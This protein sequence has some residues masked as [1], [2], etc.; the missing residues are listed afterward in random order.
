MRPSGP[1][2]KL[3]LS[4]A[5]CPSSAG[6]VA[7]CR[8]MNA[9]PDTTLMRPAAAGCCANTGVAVT[10]TATTRPADNRSLLIRASWNPERPF[11]PPAESHSK[12]DTDLQKWQCTYPD[13]FTIWRFLLLRRECAPAVPETVTA[14]GS[15]LR[16]HV[17]SWRMP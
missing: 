15:G 3:S 5:S 16:A 2:L 14:H 17:G 12:Q 7:F 4:N 11:R 13:V 1:V 9:E 6:I 10:S 8:T